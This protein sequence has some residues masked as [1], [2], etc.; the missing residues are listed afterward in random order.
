MPVWPKSFYTFGLSLGTASTEWKL[1]RKGS[2]PG[3][4]EKVFARLVP[5]LAAASHWR[6]AGLEAGMTYPKFQARVPVQT[7]ALLAPAIEQMKR[8]EADILW[9][10]RCTLFA[11]TAGSSTGVSRHLPMTEELLAH[12]R[13]AGRDAVLYYT[14]RVRNAGVF[15]GRH[16]LHGGTAALTPASTPNPAGAFV[17][18]LSG[19]AGLSLPAWSD[20]HLYEPGIAVARIADPDQR[21]AALAARVAQADVSLIAGLPGA[22]EQ[23]ARSLVEM[24]SEGGRRIPHLQAHWPNLEC[25]VYGGEMVGPYTEELRTLL[26][27]DVKFH[28]VYAASEAFIA[29]QDG[30]SNHGLRL[31]ADLGVFFEFIPMTEFD[32]N[33]LEQLGPKA[34]P[35]A[36]VKAGVDY[37]LLLTTPGGLARYVL[38]DVVQF[39]STTP[40]R[41]IY[42]GRTDLQLNRLG[43]R[44]GERLVTEALV[45]TCN[46][47]NWSIV[48]FHVAPL[49]IGGSLTGQQRGRHEWWVELRPGTIAT[50]TGPQ[51]SSELDTALM[52]AHEPY[53]T[54][55]KNG[56]LEAPVVRLVMPGVFEHWLRFQ[57]RWGGQYKVPRCGRDRSIA[58]QLAQITNFAPD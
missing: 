53:A 19:I 42:T 16:L 4:Q 46:R 39:T 5:Q 24:W 27:P 36:G 33:R 25:L 38:G 20:R 47:Y 7:H 35:L 14:V 10:G 17:G 18:E 15:G 56:T 49:V 40:P 34:V 30:E 8:G 52:A 41:L 1:R 44:T 55:R 13:R 58:D 29:S 22:V 28:E 3:E 57:Q 23:L 11:A 43:E 45:S 50:P 32:E 2:A 37:A 12:F 54:R 21:L 26:G 48:N 31:M 6:A 51:L 9:P